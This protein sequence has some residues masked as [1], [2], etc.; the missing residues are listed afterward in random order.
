MSRPVLAGRN[1]SPD[2]AADRQNLMAGLTA[3]DALDIHALRERW[4]KVFG[5]PAPKAFSRD[6]LARAIAHRLQ[7]DHFGLLDRETRILMDK[8][9]NGGETGRRLKIGTVLT[10]EH[11]GTLH[12]VIVMP[13]GFRWQDKP[14][15]SL[16]KIA[17][18]IT[19]TSW[20]GP[21]FFGLRDGKLVGTG[22]ADAIDRPFAP[23]S[24]DYVA[25][26]P[27]WSSDHVSDQGPA[28]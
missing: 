12:E 27:A 9:A 28:L 4:W 19:G 5:R 14:F 8:I 7:E 18:A 22:D 24:R 17:R 13:D 11:G 26:K 1:R 25:I 3:L 6:L 16:S 15:T 20:N 10:R 23:V 21:R 2:I